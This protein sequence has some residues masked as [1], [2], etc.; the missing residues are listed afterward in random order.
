MYRPAVIRAA[1][2]IALGLGLVGCARGGTPGSAPES[3]G[4]PPAGSA[5]APPPAG[6]APSPG[7]SGGTCTAPRSAVTVTEADNGATVCLSVGGSLTVFLRA[8]ADARWAPP[9]GDGT[10]LRPA[11]QRGVKVP[12]DVTAGFFTAAVAG[13]GSVTSS[14]PGCGSPPPGGA[15]CLSLELFRVRVLAG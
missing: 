10:V 12:L 15:A 11:P 5:G 1:L 13:E 9:E 7:S 6:S 8:S 14:R 2:V 3:G 4:S